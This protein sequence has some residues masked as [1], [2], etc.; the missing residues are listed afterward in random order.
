MT[1]PGFREKAR[2]LLKHGW[3]TTP[4]EQQINLLV[5]LNPMPGQPVHR[6]VLGR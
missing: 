1:P 3:E 2:Q 5:Q 4:R 6:L